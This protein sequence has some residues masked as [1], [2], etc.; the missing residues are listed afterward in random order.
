MQ[1]AET[2]LFGPEAQ[3]EGLPITVVECNNKMLAVADIISHV[4]SL[5]DDGQRREHNL[6]SARYIIENRKQQLSSMRW[7]QM[8]LRKRHQAWKRLTH[9]TFYLLIDAMV[10]FTNSERDMLSKFL[11]DQMMR[12]KPASI[13]DEKATRRHAANA[14]SA[15]GDANEEHS[16]MRRLILDRRPAAES[17]GETDERAVALRELWD[18]L[19]KAND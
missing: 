3:N 9:Y 4:L 15:T 16:M 7:Q 5:N 10:G 11:N 12:V 2:R 8:S 1:D 18:E 6:R 19:R 13:R 14:R 17:Q